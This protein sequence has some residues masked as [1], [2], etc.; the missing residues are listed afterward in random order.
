MHCASL[1]SFTTSLLFWHLRF[2]QLVWNV[3]AWWR[4]FCL[5]S[6]FPF[7]LFALPNVLTRHPLHELVS[8][9]WRQVEVLICFSISKETIISLLASKRLQ[10][11][12][13]VFM[14]DWSA[15]DFTLDTLHGWFAGEA[16]IWVCR[17]RDCSYSC[18][19][20]Y[21][22]VSFYCFCHG[23]CIRCSIKSSRSYTI[24][25][26]LIRIDGRWLFL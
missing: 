21:R 12:R 11:G 18:F 19:L 9:N 2:V 5:S 13:S 16:L 10:I 14:S 26:S 15:P 8:V 17:N 25:V 24:I 1:A 20:I 3:F 4:V 6:W 22:C 23:V 7:F